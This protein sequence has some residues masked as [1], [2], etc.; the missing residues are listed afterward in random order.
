MEV[1][2]R[3]YQYNLVQI[4]SLFNDFFEPTCPPKPMTLDYL[5][6]LSRIA[7]T[8]NVNALMC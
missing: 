4:Y 2:S 6:R 7:K 8:L 5:L 3:L 1:I